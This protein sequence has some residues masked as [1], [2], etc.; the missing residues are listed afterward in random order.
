MGGG[1]MG[2]SGSTAEGLPAQTEILVKEI[3]P[4]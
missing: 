2:Y 3:V 4:G 1:C